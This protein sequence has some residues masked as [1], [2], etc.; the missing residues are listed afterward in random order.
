MIAGECSGEGCTESHSSSQIQKSGGGLLLT[1]EQM[2]EVI[3]MEGTID[4]SLSFNLRFSYLIW[5]LTMQ[6]SC[7][8]EDDEESYIPAAEVQEFRAQMRSVME[9]RQELRETLKSRFAQLCVNTGNPPQKIW[10]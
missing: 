4:N 10:K 2:L 3:T 8:S 9:K 6:E 1:L 5:I 7:S